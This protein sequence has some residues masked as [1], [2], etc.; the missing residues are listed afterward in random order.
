VAGVLIRAAGG[1]LWRSGPDGLE[2]GLVHRPRY[3][4]WSMPK[5]KLEGGEHPL[6]AACR[7]VVE[8]TGV[9][10]TVGRRLPQQ[11]YRLG[12]DRKTVQ[13]WAMAALDGAD[14][15][16][17]DEVDV[18]YWARPADAAHRLS[19]PADR[20]LLHSFL[21][22]P[23]P[24]ATLLLVRHA[25][26]GSRSRWRGEDRL[27][28]LDP[29]GQ[30]QA[31][32]LRGA[33]RW[34]RPE[35]VLSADPERCVQ[36]VRPLAEDLGVSVEVDPA[37]SESAYEKDPAAVLQ[38]VLEVAG[39]GGRTVVCTQGTVIPG[40]VGTLGIEHGV[41]VPAGKVPARKASVWAL[42]FV[43]DRLVAADYYPDLAGT[44]A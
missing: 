23:P 28:P 32:T 13:Y 42:S 2:V 6:Y 35:R 11:E 18:L 1:V 39:A 15:V 36:T 17:S 44:P 41:A 26:A 8:E 30:V 21:A 25:K 7:E 19:Y 14:F 24:T 38:R 31:E 9:R 5:G 4:D 10:P 16:A 27:R 12:R 37:I 43:D 22:V 20:D 40:V 33:L 34:F 3:D 29:A